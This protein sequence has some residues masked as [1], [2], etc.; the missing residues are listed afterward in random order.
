MLD[1]VYQEDMEGIEA[2]V[3]AIRQA[4]ET[5]MM[6]AHLTPLLGNKNSEQNIRRH[7]VLALT[8]LQAKTAVPVLGA[9][10]KADEDDGVR[11]L[12]VAALEQIDPIAAIPYFQTA[13]RDREKDIQEAAFTSLGIAIQQIAIRLQTELEAEEKTAVFAALAQIK[14]E[15]FNKLLRTDLLVLETGTISVPEATAIALSQIAT[16]EAITTL[17]QFLEEKQQAQMRQ[18][19]LSSADLD[20]LNSTQR[21]QQ[22]QAKEQAEEQVMSS[23]VTALRDIAH[24]DVLPCLTK[25]LRKNLN[26]RVRRLAASALGRFAGETAVAALVYALLHDGNPNVRT[27]A[28]KRLREYIDW[29]GKTAQLLLVLQAGRLT[30]A[31]IDAPLIITAVNPPEASPE[32]LSDYFIAQAIDNEQDERITAVLAAL[33]IASANSSMTLAAERID[34]Y[35]QKSGVTAEQLQQLRVEVGGSKALD[36]ILRQLGENLKKNFQEPINDL[37]ERTSKVWRQTILIAQIGFI[38]RAT[39]SVSLFFIGAYL[40][41]DSYQAIKSGIDPALIYGPSV[42]FVAGL[43]TMLTMIFTGPLKEIRKAV[44]DVGTATTVFIAYIH[45]ILQISHTFSYYYLQ[46]KI[47]FEELEK[48]GKLIEDTMRDT[49]ELLQNGDGNGRSEE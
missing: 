16:P 3:T 18:E 33:I 7:T 43:G 41:L 39:M 37:N 44:G 6:V 10:L 13:Q 26:F 9:A 49:V 12:T 14:S 46:R 27:V 38:L 31:D 15:N 4:Q 24:E 30:R 20:Q 17:C 8:Q 34:A 32:R 21:I 29:Q 25:T 42:S 36:P 28:H 35:Q 47:N 1:A 11:R 19:Q 45:R 48:A 40:V 5:E 23:V 22:E 2:A